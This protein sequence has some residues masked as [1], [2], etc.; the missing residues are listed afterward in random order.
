MWIGVNVTL[1]RFP[2][3]KNIMSSLFMDNGHGKRTSR[4][5]F[6]ALALRLLSDGGRAPRDS[7]SV[8]SQRQTVRSPVVP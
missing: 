8:N 3:P 7:V 4:A 2:P 5:C 6:G 1:V